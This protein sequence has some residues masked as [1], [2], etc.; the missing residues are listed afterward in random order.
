MAKDF[1]VLKIDEDRMTDGKALAKEI[2]GGE[3]GGIPWM[4]VLDGG[5]KRVVTSDGP[6]GNIGYPGEPGEIA[7]FL[8]MLG[9]AAKRLTPAEIKSIEQEL[10]VRAEKLHA[11]T[12]G[13]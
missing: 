1:V 3:E 7:W 5:G 4:V 10:K 12:T 6:K 13:R 11:G 9:K 8:E 2:R